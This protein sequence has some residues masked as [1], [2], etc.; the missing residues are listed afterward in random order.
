MQLH[1]TDARHRDKILLSRVMIP[2]PRTWRQRKLTDMTDHSSTAPHA[3]MTGTNDHGMRFEP[4]E[5]TSFVADDT[6]AGRAIGQLLAFLFCILLGLMISAT[7]WTM[8][9][10]SR[11][12]N[13]FEM[14]P[15]TAPNH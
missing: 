7:L 1:S 4:Q 15:I 2:A 9:Y 12:N 3:E 14:A 13:P 6:H 10:Q 5:L 8:R 11:G